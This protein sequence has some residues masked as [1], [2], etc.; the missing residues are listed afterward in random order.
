MHTIDGKLHLSAS[1]LVNHLACRHLTELNAEV[2]AG[3][4]AAPSHWDPMLKLLRERGLAHER[5]YI[6][7]LQDAGHAV[8]SIGGV[9]ID[10]EKVASTV[11]AMRSGHDIIVQG[12]L[13]DGRWSGRTDILRRVDVPSD[14]GGWSYEVIDTKL[15]RETRSGTIL[16]LS[17]YSDLVCSV[18][19][20]TP[21]NM[22]VVAPWT[23]FE[24]ESYRTGDYAA[25]YRLVKRWLES[26]L[27][28]RARE[29]TYP[30]PKEHC[31]VCRWSASAMGAGAATTILA[32]WR[33]YRA[34][35]ST[36]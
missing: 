24:A 26:S 20:V 21:E 35:T 34:A 6:D 3:D 14:L 32:S 33:A 25:Y 4:R 30:D 36:S 28:D 19:G 22:Y 9:G 7:H 8:T 23:E 29:P 13:A 15:A 10:D 16:Q 1:D 17:L 18:Q 5:Q 27:V 12:A 11:G 31:L 2:A